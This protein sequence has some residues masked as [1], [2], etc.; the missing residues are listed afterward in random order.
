ML[1]GDSHVA[2][3]KMPVTMDVAQAV[4]PNYTWW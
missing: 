2:Y 3:S 1:F 4:D